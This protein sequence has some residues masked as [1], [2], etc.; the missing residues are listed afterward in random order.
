MPSPFPGMDPY[1]EAP[2]IWPDLHNALAAETPQRTESDPAEPL[3]CSSRDAPGA[4]DRRGREVDGNG[5][6]RISPWSASHISEPRRGAW[7]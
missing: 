4:R 3:L 5:S 1:L 2:H 7:P 6:S